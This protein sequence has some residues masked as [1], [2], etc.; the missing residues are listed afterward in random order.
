[1][2]GCW[3]VD[4]NASALWGESLAGGLERADMGGHGRVNGRRRIA[5]SHDEVNGRL[6]D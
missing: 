2:V 5:P 6:G 4:D 3:M 1:M